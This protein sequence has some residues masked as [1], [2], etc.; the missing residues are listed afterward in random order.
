MRFHVLALPHTVTSKEF[1]SCAY[2]Q[3]IVKFAKMMTERGHTVIHYGHEDS[4]LLCTEH[5]SVLPREDWKIAYGDHDWRKHF[6][7]FD[8]NDHAYQTFYRNAIREVGLRKRPN[9]FILPFWGCGGKPVCDAHPDIICV[10]PGIGY[11]SGHWAMYKI[12]ES[13]AIYNAYYGLDSVQQCKQSFY[14][15]VI[16]NYFDPDDFTFLAKKDDYFLFIGRVYNGKGIQ[17]AIEAT[18]AIGAKLVVAGQNNLESC[19]YTTIPS[20]VEFVGHVDVEQRRHLMSHAKGAFVASLYNE[21]FGGTMVECLFSG[22]PVITTPWG[23]FTEN[24]LHGITGFI[25]RTFEQFTWAARNIHKINPQDCRSWALNNFSLERVAS[26]YEDFFESVLDIYGKKGWYEPH[27]DRVH[28][29]SN[30][31]Y[32]PGI[33]EKIDFDFLAAEERPFADRLAI[34]IHDYYKPNNAIDL[35]CGPGIY[36][37]ALNIA[38]VPCVGI[39]NDPRVKDQ[40]YLEQD[41]LLDLARNYSTDVAICL[42]VAEHIDPQ[43]ADDIIKNVVGTIKP[44]GALVWTAARPGQGGVGHVNCRL[45]SYW[46]EK[47]IEAGLVPDTA[48]QT[49]C[50]DYC[51]RGYH[52]GW[53]VNNLL[54]FRKPA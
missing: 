9:D 25:C 17:I 32:Y 20:H 7:K 41:N 11:G 38:G 36:T 28:L 23:A 6:F 24:N 19:G 31:R 48:A 5:V 15:V 2:T 51:K 3:K 39:D 54:C 4:D 1:V 49:S 8:I 16:P 45:K 30:T 42:E 34:W 27:P 29:T 13:Y 37:Q 26:L 44:G 43:Y 46:E 22:T 50:L 21:P 14:D 12:F 40:E 18:A 52:M 33:E 10:E 35:G 47:F 53:F